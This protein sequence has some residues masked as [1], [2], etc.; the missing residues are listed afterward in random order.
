[1]GILNPVVS[2]FS[3]VAGVP[4][5]V[6]SCPA[7]KSHAIVDVSLFKDNL[8]SDALIAVALSTES[9][10]ANLTS[11]DY[12][13]DDIELIGIVNSAELNKVVVGQ[14]E[15]LYLRVI[16]G[17]DVVVR[18]S[19]VEENNSKVLKAGRL[20]AGSIAGTAQTQIFNNNQPNTAYTSAS[21]TIF[22]TSTT[23]NAEVQAWIT[24]SA[25]PGTSDKVMKITIPF[26]DTTIVENLLL[27]PNEKIFVQSTQ[28]NCEYFVNGIVVG[29]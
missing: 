21:F 27:A 4:Q 22:N 17:P 1:M 13:I 9:N 16:Q 5:E 28:I 18:V 25:T 11:V 8:G 29:V 6:Y 10:P 15:R 20:A 12:F 26:N 23:T 3:L 14:G 24:T 19:G 2:K 7:G